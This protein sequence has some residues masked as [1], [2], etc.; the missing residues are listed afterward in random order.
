M[1]VVNLF[2]GPGAG[3]STTGAMLFGMLQIAGYAAEYVPE[4]AKVLTWQNH[5]TALK[6]QLYLFAKQDHRLE[7]LREQPLDFVIMDGPLLNAAMYVQRDYFKNFEPLVVEVFNSYDNANFFLER[8]P[9][10][11]YQRTGRNQDPEQAAKLCEQTLAL[12]NRY[13]VPFTRIP[14]TDSCQ[15]NIFT[16]L[17]GRPWPLDL[18]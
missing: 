10:K 18:A 16:A 11:K 7:V 2:A 17:T 6:D 8:N 5:T 4:F 3:K 1:K 12:L 15:E 14:V 13:R 9:H